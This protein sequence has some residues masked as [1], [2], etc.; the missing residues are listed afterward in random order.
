MYWNVRKS[1]TKCSFWC[2]TCLVSLLWLLW[3]Q[4]LYDF[5]MCLSGKLKTLVESFETGCNVVLRG[6]RGTSWHSTTFHDLKWFCVA[7]AIILPRFP[8]TR[9]IFR[10]RCSTLAT[11]IVTWRGR[12]ST[13]DVSCCVVFANHIVRAARRGDTHCSTLYT[14][15]STLYTLQSQFRTFNSTLNTPHFRL[16][17]LHSTPYTLHCTLHTLH[18]APH[19]LHFELYTPHFSL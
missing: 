2:S 15:H 11:S 13:W 16:Y 12:R 4:C 19:N 10:G 1:R 8:Q 6:K 14:F 17:T 18:F 3:S 7:S 5:Y 9:C